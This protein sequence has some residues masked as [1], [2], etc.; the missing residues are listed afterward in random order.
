MASVQ[1]L[2]GCLEWADTYFP[3]YFL[4]FL[5]NLSCPHSTVS[6]CDL[7]SCVF[8]FSTLRER[9]K[10]EGGTSP[11]SGTKSCL[12][13]A[14]QV[15]GSRETCFIWPMGTP[16]FTASRNAHAAATSAHTNPAPGVE[17]LAWQGVAW[18]LTA[19]AIC[20]VSDVPFL[21]G[22]C[23][24]PI[25]P[26]TFAVPVWICF[27]TSLGSGAHWNCHLTVVKWNNEL[28]TEFLGQLCCSPSSQKSI[29]SPDW[30]FCSPSFV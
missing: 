15:F 17:S 14:S 16:I 10:W 30:L 20:K 18:M 28:W 8:P 24:F 22:N 26:Q 23:T 5:V 29:L 13:A 11:W 6:A 25:I 27:H 12:V 19:S 3:L 1:L 9:K 4:G 7:N 2:T 21:A